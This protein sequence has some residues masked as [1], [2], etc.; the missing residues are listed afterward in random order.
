MRRKSLETRQEAQEA[1][2]GAKHDAS[3]WQGSNEIM[4]PV[5][6]SHTCPRNSGRRYRLQVR[7]EQRSRGAQGLEEAVSQFGDVYG[8]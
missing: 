6:S 1:Q 3:H 2:E 7:Y 8:C 4:G 5:F